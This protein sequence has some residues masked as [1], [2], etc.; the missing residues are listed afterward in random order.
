MAITSLYL[1]D[2][3]RPPRPPPFVLVPG[4][5]L[6]C[7]HRDLVHGHSPWLWPVDAAAHPG[8]RLDPRNLCAGH[9]H[10]EYFLGH[11]RDF[12]GHG[13]GPFW[14]LS[15]AGDGR[16]PLRAGA[17]WHVAGRYPLDVDALDRR[18]AG[19][20]AGGHHLRCGLWRDRAQCA[21]GTQVLGHGHGRRGGLLRAIFNGAD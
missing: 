5:G 2:A 17:N 6:R 9:G 19:R 16:G 11:C 10:P 12:C 18:H 21:G 14:C 1:E 15:G 7:R 3:K 4:F 13:G 8:P 20:C